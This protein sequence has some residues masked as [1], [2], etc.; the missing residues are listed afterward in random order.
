MAA[1]FSLRDEPKPPPPLSGGRSPSSAISCRATFLPVFSHGASSPQKGLFKATVFFL[2][3]QVVEFFLF[4]KRVAA[5]PKKGR[6]PPFYSLV[7]HPSVEVFFKLTASNPS[8]VAQLFERAYSFPAGKGP[9]FPYARTIS[10]LRGGEVYREH[11]SFEQRRGLLAMNR[12]F[13]SLFPPPRAPCEP[14]ARICPSLP[15][16]GLPSSCW[17]FFFRPLS[18]FS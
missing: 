7:F 11:F 2:A 8:R 13:F 4:P 18:G 3:E 10:F 9:S 5:A 12:T 17:D 1:L 16:G 15:P 6:P 14:F